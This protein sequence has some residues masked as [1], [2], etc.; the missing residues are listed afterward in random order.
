MVRNLQ[1]DNDSS[2]PDFIDRNGHFRPEQERYY[3]DLKSPEASEDWWGNLHPSTSISAK[4]LI[5]SITDGLVL[6]QQSP[7]A[8]AEHTRGETSPPD[9]VDLDRLHEAVNAALESDINKEE[10][11]NTHTS[12]SR[13]TSEPDP[14][15]DL[16]KL[17]FFVNTSGDTEMR[18]EAVLYFEQDPEGLVNS[19][20]WILDAYWRAKPKHNGVNVLAQFNASQQILA[21]LSG[22]LQPKAAPER[23]CPRVSGL[24]SVTQRPWMPDKYFGR[25]ENEPPHFFLNEKSEIEM[26][27]RALKKFKAVKP[28]NVEIAEPWLRKAYVTASMR[29]S[30]P[31][32]KVATKPGKNEVTEISRLHTNE[33]IYLDCGGG[34]QPPPGKN[35]RAVWCAQEQSAV[36]EQNDTNSDDIMDEGASDQESHPVS[37][38]TAGQEPGAVTEGRKRKKRRATGKYSHFY[39]LPLGALRILGGEKVNKMVPT[40]EERPFHEL[41]SR[42]PP[43]NL[44]LRLIPFDLSVEEI[45]K[46]SDSFA[47]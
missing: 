21:L 45:L 30:K 12:H 25:T 20:T 29:G 37:P 19:E 36:G 47:V 11:M 5:G 28:F 38:T 41:K 16:F 27:Q 32:L 3:P 4:Y 10:E 31:V 42:A 1:L 6:T 23:R 39:K 18:Q 43:P 15:S 8:T 46:V 35:W 26:T 24:F 34:R 17:L 33:S 2:K 14:S 7:P 9:N 22:Q 13:N 44:N 40:Q